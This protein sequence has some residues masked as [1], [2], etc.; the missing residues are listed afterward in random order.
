[1]YDLLVDEV[2]VAMIGL[3]WVQMVPRKAY[4][5]FVPLGLRTEHVLPLKRLARAHLRWP[6]YAVVEGRKEER[7]ARAI[8]FR[9]DGEFW[10]Y[11]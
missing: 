1:M 10:R 2:R 4:L 7:F 3:T 11:N 6:V 5:W 9:K 8:G